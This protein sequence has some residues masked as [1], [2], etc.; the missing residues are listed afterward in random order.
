METAYQNCPHCGDWV[1]VAPACESCGG[2]LAESGPNAAAASAPAPVAPPDT[3]KT[4]T[5]PSFPLAVAGGAERNSPLA[6]LAAIDSEPDEDDDVEDEP[7]LN[8]VAARKLRQLDNDVTRPPMPLRSAAP[9]PPSPPP[10]G[11]V[12][13][14]FNIA[15]AFLRGE[16]SSFN[17]SLEPSPQVADR[18]SDVRLRLVVAGLDPLEKHVPFFS[19]PAA[20]ALNL[21][22]LPSASGIDIPADV[23]LSYRLDGQ[24][25]EF[26]GTLLWDCFP[27]EEAAR[28]VE[29][30]VVQLGDLK[31]DA[32]ADQNIHI[33]SNLDLGRHDSRA[34]QLRRLKLAP[35]WQDVTLY[36]AGP[37]PPPAAAATEA[38]L[39]EWS[40][41][42][43]LMQGR[44]QLVL[45]R[46]RE[47]C[48]LLLRCFSAQ[49]ELTREINQSLS[50]RHALLDWLGDHWVLRDGSR[51]EGRLVASSNGCWLDGERLP[52]AGTAHLPADRASRLTFAGPSAD[53]P[54]VFG[55]EAH[56]LGESGALLLRRSDRRPE[57]VLLLPHGTV[58]LEAVGAAFAERR[59]VRRQGAFALEGPEGFQWLVPGASLHLAGFHI[60][61]SSPAFPSSTP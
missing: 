3:D 60:H 23:F 26:H 15:R 31:V 7:D 33:L 45:G 32:A 9:P 4:T 35:V 59:L 39:L 37:P 19:G 17:F 12:R 24:R 49:G 40:G 28:F 50:R 1:P 13:L 30:L 52:P 20:M 11:S 38:L 16:W 14:R 61:V 34:D 46:Q 53:Y 21:S 58:P 8:P 10:A 55:F 5:V 47:E 25:R 41:R 36:A 44:T 48:H 42:S 29:N 22:V 56:P 51:R 6:P 57:D 27:P 2:V 43:L 18:L 54:E